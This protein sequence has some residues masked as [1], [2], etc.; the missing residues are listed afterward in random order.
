MNFKNNNI[1]IQNCLA[2]VYIH[3]FATILIL[4]HEEEKKSNLW[5]K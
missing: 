2:S 5:C 1:Q 4:G 3:V